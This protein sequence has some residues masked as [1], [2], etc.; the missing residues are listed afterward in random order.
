MMDLV[1]CVL[2]FTILTF[3]SEL[4]KKTILQIYVDLDQQDILCFTE[5]N[6]VCCRKNNFK[7]LIII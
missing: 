5:N 1:I 3:H 4:V 2:K 6:H 7:A